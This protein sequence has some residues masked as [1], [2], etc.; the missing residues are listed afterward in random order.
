[1][2]NEE[3]DKARADEAMRRWLL[4]DG[5][6]DAAL[7]RI[8]IDIVN[9]GWTPAQKVDPLVEALREGWTTEDCFD[10]KTLAAKVNEFLAKRGLKIVSEDNAEPVSEGQLL[11]ELAI[12]YNHKADDSPQFTRWQMVVAIAHGLRL[13]TNA[14]AAERRAGIKDAIEWTGERY[15]PT[16]AQH[17]RDH[18]FGGA[19]DE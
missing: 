13:S 11:K 10:V 17:M 2:T 16:S 6:T 1:M 18:F 9:T 19:G 5:R 4:D 8:A 12:L 14:L 3:L 7:A 15:G